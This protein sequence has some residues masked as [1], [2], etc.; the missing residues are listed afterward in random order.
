MDWQQSRLAYRFDFALVPVLITF[1]AL[2]ME[3]SVLSIAEIALG[4]VGWT[5]LEYWT[6]RL[7]FHRFMRAAHDL[8]HERPGGYDA[9]P[10]WMTT[11]IHLALGAIAYYTNTL[12]AFAGL[13]LGY[14][15]YIWTHDAIH[16]GTARGAW[17]TSRWRHHIIHHHGYGVNFGVALYWWDRLFG[18]YLDPEQVKRDAMRTPLF[19]G[20][21]STPKGT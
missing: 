17:L 12:G 6:H 3:Y 15:L 9:V 18:T 16:H 2:L 8:H 19:H 1:A 13:E 5:F 4:F 10:P 20:W 11:P 14:W 7:L 21:P